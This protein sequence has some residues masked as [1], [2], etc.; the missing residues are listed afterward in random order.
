MP[1][2][3]P[4]KLAALIR[5]ERE[6]TGKSVRQLAGSAGVSPSTVSRLEHAKSA[7]PQLIPLQRIAGALEVDVEDFYAAAGYRIAEHLPELRPYLRAKY[8]LPD[9]AATQI[10]EY[11]RALRDHWTPPD[12]K[13]G[14]NDNSGNDTK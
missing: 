8:N 14:S 5:H 7:Q 11:F 1:P 13:E 9:Q 12:R 4:R 6:R 2:N 10:D 3:G